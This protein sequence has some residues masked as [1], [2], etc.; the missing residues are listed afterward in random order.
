MNMNERKIVALVWRLLRCRKTI[1]INQSPLHINIIIFCYF[2][3][4]VVCFSFHFSKKQHV[5]SIIAMETNWSTN[6]IDLFI[7]HLEFFSSS[8]I[9]YI[10]LNY[11][12][13][14]D[15]TTKTTTKINPF[16]FVYFDNKLFYSQR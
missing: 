12:S 2:Y 3:I 16:I 7:F 1:G 8:Q 4:F 15:D 6:F 13:T 14:A 9:K 11:D 10:H 5:V